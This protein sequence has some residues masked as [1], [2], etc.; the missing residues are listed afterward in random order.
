MSS[1]LL[2]T[3]ASA[4]ASGATAASAAAAAAAGLPAIGAISAVPATAGLFGVGGAFSA[5]TALG[6]LSTA[7]RVISSAGSLFS[8]LSQASALEQNASLARQQAQFDAAQKRRETQSLLSTQRA[9]YGASGVRVNV[10]SPV[11]FIAE[12]AEQGELDALMTLYGGK[13]ESEIYKSRARQARVGGFLGAG[14][15][16][17]SMG[18]R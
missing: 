2:G 1:I 16:L 17:L 4:A 12:T 8:G 13:A 18:G 3:A 6:T 9:R 14:T 5:A 15:S 10:G 11:D 7:G